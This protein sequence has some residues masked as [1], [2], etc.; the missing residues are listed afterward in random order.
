MTRAQPSA[1][2]GAVSL[3]AGDAARLALDRVRQAGAHSADVA[4]VEGTSIEA[5]VRGEEID[6]VKQARERTLGLRAFV[7]R[8]GGLSC[9]ITSSSDL[10]PASIDRL[11]SETVALARATAP[12]PHAGLP[13]DGLADALPDL[14]LFDPAD[15]GA[16][17]QDRIAQA[18]AAERGARAVDPRITRS[19]GSEAG[20]AFHRV[21]YAST[22][23]FA[24]A[25]ESAA[26]F[27]V[28]TPIA[29]E[30]GAMQSD[31]WMSVAR[32]LAALEAPEA[33]GRRAAERALGQLGARRV[34]T[35]E[36]PV[37]FDARSARSLLANLVACL[38]GYAVYRGSSFLANR[39]GERI[40]SANVTVIDDG[41]LPGGLG[42]RP[43]D[44]EGQ[45]TRRNRVIEG[46]RL[47]TWLLDVYSARKLGMASTGNASRS[48]GSG[49]GA[50][51]TNF[52]LEP[53]DASLAQMIADTPRGLL[54]TGLF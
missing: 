2:P 7:R 47:E 50:G 38:S 16:E 12:D 17:V 15:R 22:A 33:V 52:W 51:P 39:L 48:P 36:V 20:S 40:A 19:E 25:Y 32:S 9:A 23:G 30:N 44:G 31:S 41:R 14:A 8:R 54:V 18:R 13:E 1:D 49:P 27:L 11:A 6:F 37:I 29:A 28:S 34:R 26:H 24:G 43:F 35:N 4:V 46:G 53:G 5:R 10:S 42:S 21:A 45:A 3:T